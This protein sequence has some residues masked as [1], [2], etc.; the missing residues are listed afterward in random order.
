MHGNT[1]TAANC[2]RTIII[3]ESSAS[4]EKASYSHESCVTSEPC[5]SG[6]QSD[7][8]LCN[9]TAPERSLTGGWGPGTG[10]SAPC[11]LV[12]SQRSPGQH[13]PPGS[14]ARCSCLHCL[15]SCYKSGSGK[16][17]NHV[18]NPYGWSNES[19]IRILPAT[20]PFP[21]PFH[22]GSSSYKEQIRIATHTLSFYME[23]VDCSQGI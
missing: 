14:G 2:R 7:H 12:P 9:P 13:S 11:L 19:K 23:Q 16:P 10:V 4:T 5:G 1:A 6:A 8:T 21:M 22:R 18:A 3:A 17:P 15:P 20:T